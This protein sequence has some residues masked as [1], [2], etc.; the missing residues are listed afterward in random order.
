MS[1]LKQEIPKTPHPAPSG[2][3]TWSFGWATL[4]L[5]GIGTGVAVAIAPSVQAPAF[6]VDDAYITQHNA[7][8]LASGLPDPAFADATPLYGTTSAVHLVLVALAGY[9]LPVP[10]AQWCLG[11]LFGLLY[12][13]GIL[14][15]AWVLGLPGVRTA[16][17]VALGSFVGEVPHQLL[18]GLETGL[19]MAA[20][21]WLLAFWVEPSQ[22]KGRKTGLPVLVGLMPFIRPEFGALS[23]AVWVAEGIGTFRRD[24]TPTVWLR[25]SGLSLGAALPFAAWY[26][27]ETGVPWPSTVGAKRSFFAEWCLPADLK[28]LWVRTATSSFLARLGTAAVGLLCLLA[29]IRGRIGMAWGGVLI[30]AYYLEFPGALG[31]Y[32]HRYLYPLIVLSLFGLA[33]AM[34]SPTRALRFTASLAAA[35]ALIESV[36]FLPARWDAHR[37]MLAG[38]QQESSRLASWLTTHYPEGTTLLLHDI[39][40]IGANTR[41]SLV[42]LV[43]LKSPSSFESHRAFT[44]P[45]CG[46]ERSRATA[47]IFRSA[48]PA[49]FVALDGWDRI[50]GLTRGLASEGI[51][52]ERLDPKSKADSY[53][54]Y[55]CV[56]TAGAAK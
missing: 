24:R 37:R 48:S 20:A 52:C 27:L 23:L 10:W 34:T 30:A 7:H 21:A 39:G 12:L 15:I 13:A 14:R 4:A 28:W 51:L 19:A 46:R 31:H 54:V 16:I 36:S 5:L 43:G 33:R 18:N 2:K 11:I 50:F 32:E 40:Y 35:F 56:D 44:E 49:A 47:A 22:S 41:F 17:I 38:V 42:D 45:S 8:V 6:A 26:L 55:R 3:A 9:I 53:G 29:C 1:T 25:W